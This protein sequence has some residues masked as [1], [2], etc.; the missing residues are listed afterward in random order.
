L[1]CFFVSTPWAMPEQPL[2]T[3]VIATRM[4]QDRLR[5]WGVKRLERGP[6]GIAHGV[7]TKKH[8]NHTL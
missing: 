2:N 6:S 3:I 8:L 5:A 7:E 4:G 1:R